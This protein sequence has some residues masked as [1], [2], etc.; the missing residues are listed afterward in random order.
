MNSSQKAWLDQ[1]S[2]AAENAGVK[3]PTMQACEAA[4]ESG[5]GNSGLAKRANNLF[6]TK[7]HSTPIYETLT[8]PTKEFLKG[9]WVT[10]DA[11]WVKYP[12]LTASF[13]D[14]TDTLTRLSA[15]KNND[16]TLKYPHYAAALAAADAKVFVREV[17][18]T[19]STDPQRAEKVISIF[20]AY[21]GA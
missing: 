10:V 2:K 19:W 14:R 11:N 9:T 17:S 8:I 5:Y 16:G 6:G 12:D 7:Q 21:I 1:I 18:Q 20:E 13:K 15:A 4:L 3:F